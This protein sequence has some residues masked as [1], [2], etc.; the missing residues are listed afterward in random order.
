[1]HTPFPWRR[2]GI[3]AALFTALLSGCMPIFGKIAFLSGFSPKAV[4]A[5]R[6]SLALLLMLAV[7]LAFQRKY[8]YIYPVGLLGCFLA[9]AVNGLGSLFYYSGLER[10][11]ASLGHL[12]YSFYPIFVGLWLTLDRQP[13]SRLTLLRMGLSI[14]AIYLLTV[15]GLHPVDILGAVFLI[16]SSCLY[17]LHLI[18]NQRVL[19]EVPAP[20][21][22]L[23]NLVAMCAVVIPVYLLTD[24]SLPAAAS[25][26]FWAVWWPVIALGGVT[27]LSR[28]TLFLGVKHLGGLQTALLGLGEL[29]VAV[30]LAQWWLGERLS[31]GQ[32]IGGALLVANLV[33]VGFERFSPNVKRKSGWLAWLQ[34]PELRW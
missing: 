23:Y 6:T 27:F 1:M 28:I 11:D 18:I 14:P 25:H 3:Q 2:I 5:F 31:V 12:L 21:V 29:L 34:P 4:V 15:Q 24:R 30:F 13:I 19:Y 33:M 32:W 9:G 26:T 16:I 10:V 7:I 20:T 8:F 22:A 17:A